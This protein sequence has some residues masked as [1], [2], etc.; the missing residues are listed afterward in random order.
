MSEHH[1]S[2]F[3]THTSPLAQEFILYQLWIHIREYV[4]GWYIQIQYKYIY[5]KNC[6]EFEVYL[7]S[8]GWYGPSWRVSQM[9][10]AL[11]SLVL[12]SF[13][14]L[15]SCVCPSV[16]LSI[17]YANVGLMRLF[18]CLLSLY[19][20][21]WCNS[22]FVSLSLCLSLSLTVFVLFLSL[23]LLPSLRLSPFLSPSL[24]PRCLPHYLSCGLSHFLSLL[25]ILLSLSLPLSCCLS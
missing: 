12:C 13:A 25:F 16:R 17:F 5:V 4:L 21:M 19:L 6:R 24:L 18:A 9:L 11:S 10:L 23:S 22:L 7:F 8:F 14:L 15:P 3:D 2:E 20:C 1:R